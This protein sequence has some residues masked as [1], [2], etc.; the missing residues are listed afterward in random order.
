MP[1]PDGCGNFAGTARGAVLFQLKPQFTMLRYTLTFLLALTT[2][3]LRA[4]TL[5]IEGAVARAKQS[6]PDLA[7]ARFAVGEAYGRLLQSGRLANPELES[8]LKPNV[9]GRQ[10]TFGVGFIQRFPLTS[11]LRLERAVSGAELKAAM[12]EVHNAERLVAAEVRTL[13]VKMLAVQGLKALKETQRKN[14]V[15]LAGEAADSAKKGE[16][17]AMVAVQFELEASQLA[18]ELLQADAESAALAGQ[19]RPLLGADSAESVIVAGAL[20]APA[21]TDKS[22]AV[23]E[24]RADYQATR[25]KAEAALTGIEL[26]K[27]GRWADASYGLSAEFQRA[28]D[29]PNGLENDGFIG[30][31]FSLPLPLWNKNEGKIEEAKAAAAR[32]AREALALALRIRAEAAAAQAEM[33]AA[34]KIAAQISTALLPRAATVEEEFTKA[35]KQGQAQMTEVLRAREKRL[36]FEQSHLTALRDYHLARVRLLAAQGR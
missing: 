26:A 34:A 15:A 11:R 10:F 14:S 20:A 25:A 4:A 36:G 22:V 17:P 23:V 33:N 29:A 16:G 18:L 2:S 8:E 9:R 24:N 27:A 19:L 28:E 32:T 31:R 12:A 1:G 21:G 3:G 6:N 7:A 30:F 13:A 35:Q 5:T